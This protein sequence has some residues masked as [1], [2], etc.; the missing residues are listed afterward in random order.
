M[1]RVIP[2]WFDIDG[3]LLHTRVGHGAFRKALRDVYGWEES[4]ESVVF[5]GNTDL[6]VLMDMSLRHGGD[7]NQALSG[8][9]AFFERM[10]SYLDEGL[11]EDRPDPVPGAAELV[12]ELV[13][14][15]NLSLGLLTGNARDCALIKLKHAELHHAF[16][17]GGFGDEHADRNVLATRARENLRASLPAEVELAPG[18]VLGDTPRDALAA[19]SIGARCIGVATGAYTAADLQAAGAEHAVEDLTS[20]R[21]LVDLLL[22]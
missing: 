3:T 4:L 12:A 21:A 19:H 10:A 7:E 5:A 22:S 1:T 6:Q 8:R 13:K 16:S 14:I 17:E 15:A 9:H 11:R 2:I 20:T 18:W